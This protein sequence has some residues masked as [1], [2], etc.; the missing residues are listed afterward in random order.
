MTAIDPAPPKPKLRWYQFSLRRL[1]VCGAILGIGVGWLAVK[2]RQAEKRRQAVA[3]I[4]NLGGHV[5]YDFEYPRPVMQ[6]RRPE[7]VRPE[8]YQRGMSNVDFH[9][10]VVFISWNR[11][12][13]GDDEIEYLRVLP[14][15]REANL[16][17]TQ[18][19]DAGLVHLTGLTNL[20]HL[21]LTNTPITDVGVKNLQEALP[22][23]EI[24][25]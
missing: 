7:A 8:S 10:D 6:K 25:R 1:L 13:I 20:T 14:R 11:P 4:E 24:T 9:S 2:L 23:C 19:T 12:D 15:L 21:D 16:A 17:N 18:V 22:N 3:A 5:L